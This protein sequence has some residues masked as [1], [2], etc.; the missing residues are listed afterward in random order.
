MIPSCATK[1]RKGDVSGF[2]KFYHNMTA[3]YNGYWNA[4]EIM[5]ETF[6]ILDENH[7]DN[8]SEILPVY[9]YGNAENA[10]S[11]AGEL[12]IAIEKVTTVAAI[13][14]VSDYVDDCYVLMGTAQYLKQD[15]ESAE[16][17]FEYFQ[18]EFNPNDPS[19]RNYRKK[20]LSSDDKRKLREEERKEEQK[21]KE[22]ER[23]VKEKAREEERK[24]KEEKR[25]KDEEER[26]RKKKERDRQQKAKQD[27]KKKENDKD[28]RQKE[29][30]R[31]K[32]EREQAIK[33]RQSN[34]NKSPEKDTTT[35]VKP[36]VTETKKEV[37][38]QTI[39]KTK[40]P[41]PKVVAVANVE[42][43]EIPRPRKE[44]EVKEEKSSYYEG[45]LWL[46]RTYIERDQFSSAEFLLR[47]MW[48]DP[49]VKED[50]KK[51]IPAAQAHLAISQKRYEEAL[52]YLVLASEISDDKKDRARYA[53]IL[54]QI[55]ERSGNYAGAT[56][57]YQLSKKLGNTYEMELNAE[58][59]MIKNSY[60]SGNIG[61][62][63]AESKILKMR[64]ENKNEEYRD[65]ITL[66]LAEMGMMSD[67]IAIAKKYLKEAL[68]Y[69]NGN[70]LIQAESYYK[71]ATM[72]Y[73]AENYV[74]SK[75]YYDSTL[76]VMDKK[77]DRYEQS[78][79]LASN[80]RD[81]AR[82]LEVISTQDSLI[83]IGA[84]PLEQR[85]EMARNVLK[86]REEMAAAGAK[87]EK[88]K[89]INSVK[90]SRSRSL[91]Q[92]SFF[93]Y[94]LPTV[95]KGKEAFRNK[96][97]ERA[98]Q[99][100][101]R[102][103]EALRIAYQEEEEVV[104]TEEEEKVD[105]EELAKILKE[106]PSSEQEVN[107]AEGRIELALFELGKLYRDKLENYNKS[108]EVHEELLRRFPE[109]EKKLDTYYYL[110]LTYL[111]LNESAKAKKYRDMIINDFPDTKYA[112]ALNDP[113]FMNEALSEKARLA[114]YYDMAFAEFDKRNYQ[115][116][117]SMVEE[118]T[119]KFGEKNELKAKFA[120]L[121]A[122]TTG[123]LKGEDEYI[124]ALQDV[125]TRYPNTPEQ[126]R[127]REIMRFLKGDE[128]AFE[129]VNIEEVDD[130]F[131][132]EFEKLHY[133]AIVVFNPDEDQFNETKISIS[134]YNKDKHRLKK[135]QLADIGLNKSE[136]TKIILIRK[137]RGKDKVMEYYK[138][139]IKNASQFVDVDGVNYEVY[140]VTQRNY[141][142]IIDQ[143]SASKYRIW[144][145]N[146]YL[147]N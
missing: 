95:E 40:Q 18:Q 141:R 108:V 54:A 129:T 93:A 19:S 75:N 77:D 139:I 72:E 29:R 44:P 119:S 102:R 112:Q 134:N 63:S 121:G 76:T 100:N 47:R 142:K 16:E 10:K 97:G 56:E 135:L 132:E 138:D 99:D 41:T 8:Y 103:R 59:N 83:R 111:D 144:F 91:A 116:V 88:D 25:K 87:E 30:D 38:Q 68:Q 60:F 52:P 133:V 81:I 78:R 70:P 26:D 5:K 13:H 105:D 90:F 85:E 45:M 42:E 4:N 31:K 53:Y 79:K 94:D 143:K 73:E 28:S 137:F 39:T 110:Y 55:R 23:K 106:F 2:K 80:L 136:N 7:I 32:K 17:T 6:T 22:E 140:P 74:E 82:N 43:E 120:L 65:R 11:V 57:A 146:K 15:F 21:I 130:I 24:A 20:T 64:K 58:L 117:A 104:A 27:A 101:W 113:N 49:T 86:Q 124:S 36:P 33:D 122:M 84:L 89:P 48:D 98:L 67:D 114:N 147:Q 128:N 145:E 109:T 107:R 9:T 125:V 118:S 126:T 69:S 62:S 115:R 35:I 123:N 37:T 71:I 127:A 96:W 1:K 66:T 92:S 12:D 131:E 46:A 50:I 3:K 14:D 61:F 51:E 34:K